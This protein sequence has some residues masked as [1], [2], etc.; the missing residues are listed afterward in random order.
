[1]SKKDRLAVSGDWA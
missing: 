1:V